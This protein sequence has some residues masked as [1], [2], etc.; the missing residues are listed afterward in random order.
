[1]NEELKSN[2]Y[3]GIRI[4][5]VICIGFAV[6]GAMWKGTEILNLDTPEFMMVYGIGG[7]IISEILARVF[8]KKILK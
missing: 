1:M 3:Y 5:Q 7:A 2:V 8:K 4:V 6:F